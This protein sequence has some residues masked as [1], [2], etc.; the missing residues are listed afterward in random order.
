MAGATA[1]KLDYF[2]YTLRQVTN[3][4]Q[5]IMFI[6]VSAGCYKGSEE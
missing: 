5:F 1:I 6:D 4:V 3:K 2:T